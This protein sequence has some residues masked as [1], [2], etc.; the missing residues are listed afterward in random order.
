ME[1][2]HSAVGTLGTIMG[3][4]KEGGCSWLFYVRS[5]RTRKWSYIR[6]QE[7]KSGSTSNFLK[8]LEFYHTNKD[9]IDWGG[10]GGL[11]GLFSVAD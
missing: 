11:W 4:G 6:K 2:G 7:N 8:Q 5:R 3:L 9:M 1:N 10:G